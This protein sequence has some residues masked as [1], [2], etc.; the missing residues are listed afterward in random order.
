MAGA[1]WR[2]FTR[3]TLASTDVQQYLMD[4]AVMAFDSASQRDAELVAPQPGMH[5]YLRDTDT[6]YVRVASGAWLPL[7]RFLGALSAWPTE[8]GVRRGDVFFSVP[9]QCHFV[10][11]A[12]AI[13]WQQ[14]E[15]PSVNGIAG[16]TALQSAVSAAG[17]WITDGFQVYAYGL[18]RLY[19]WNR[20]AW[21]LIGGNAGTAVGLTTGSGDPQ[22]G[23]GAHSGNLQHHGNGMATVQF[24]IT[25]AG[26][27]IVPS[28]TGKITNSPLLILPAGWE[29]R[30][31]TSIGP[32][33][34]GNRS[35]FAYMSAGSRTV[36]LTGVTGSANIATGAVISLAGTYPLAAPQD[37]AS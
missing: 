32:G 36:T 14:V 7:G 18:E 11:G 34:G 24:D 15:I 13:D 23:W 9:H 20:S 26:A 37:L 29:S 28:T 4:Q 30:T 2:Q 8:P 17:M 27:D 3:Q 35:A 33:S 21:R 6:T 25:R 22:T 5:C 31:G 10:S 12:S 19:M 1:G 16:R